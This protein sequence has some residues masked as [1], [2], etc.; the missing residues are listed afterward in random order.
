MLN[1][2][3]LCLVFSSFQV[4]SVVLENYGGHIQS[5]TSAVNQENKIASI[6][7]ELSPAEAETR[8]AS[9]TRIVDDRG[10]AIVSV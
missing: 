7:K 8:I 3:V 2:F 1:S 6:D 5:S 9:W 4:V 10:K